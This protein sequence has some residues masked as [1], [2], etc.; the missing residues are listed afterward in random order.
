MRNMSYPHLMGSGWIRK[1]NR[2]EGIFWGFFPGLIPQ[3]SVGAQKSDGMRI[4]PR[5]Q[6]QRE[7]R[8]G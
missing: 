1:I 6:V 3:V 8:C 2:V 4:A 7:C 5:V